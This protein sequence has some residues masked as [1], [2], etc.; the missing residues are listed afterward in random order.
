MPHPDSRGPRPANP[1]EAGVLADTQE[2][3]DEGRVHPA[4]YTHP[5]DVPEA[6]AMIRRLCELQAEVSSVLGYDHAADCFCGEDGF[7]PL[8]HPSDYRNEG[9]SVEFIEKATREALARVR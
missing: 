6:Q 4:A 8:R 5:M 3:R 9:L 1:S 7:W 2:A